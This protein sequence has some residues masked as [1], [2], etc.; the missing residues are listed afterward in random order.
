[1]RARESLRAVGLALLASIAAGQAAVGQ[2]PAPRP[3]GPGTIVGVVLDTI[4]NPVDSVE[5]LVGSIQRRT[6]S[7]PDGTFRFDDIKPGKYNVAAR[8]PGYYPQVRSVVVDDKGGTVSFSLAP[9]VRAL[10][11]VVSS[12]PLGGL[13]GVIGD[14]AYNIVSGALISVVASDHRARSDSMGLFHIALKAGKYMVRVERP[15]YR[16][17]LVSVTIPNDSGRRMTV[18][19]TPSTRAQDARDAMALDSLEMRL[20]VRSPVWSTIYTREDIN[21]LGIEDGA[22]LARLG[23]NSWKGSLDDRCMAIIDGGPIKAPLWSIDAADL[24]MMEVYS[25][26]RGSGRVTSIKPGGTTAAESS[27][28]DDYCSSVRVFVWL[29]K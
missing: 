18:W 23:A 20:A 28:A 9:G 10:P 22:Q 25:P 16:S 14:T 2:Q 27:N 29:R 17:R 7:G 19:L 26:R 6:R 8:R 21:R 11:P 12:A 15:G 1:M 4:G 24:E 13:S 3:A 5:L